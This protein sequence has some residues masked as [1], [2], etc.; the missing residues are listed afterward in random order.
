VAGPR[1]MAARQRWS[2]GHVAA[3]LDMVTEHYSVPSSSLAQD[4]SPRE[5][6]HTLL[7]ANHSA[8]TNASAWLPAARC[9]APRILFRLLYHREHSLVRLRE[10]YRALIF[11]F[12]VATC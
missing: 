3:Q 12:Y 10:N 5:V 1:G 4:L 6:I 8:G 2:R 9:T 7:G 11:D